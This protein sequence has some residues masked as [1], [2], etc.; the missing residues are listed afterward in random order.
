M[1]SEPTVEEIQQWRETINL[2]V[3]HGDGTISID[4]AE[5]RRYLSA[6]R[7]LA[8]IRQAG[9]L[10]PDAREHLDNIANWAG[11]EKSTHKRQ[12]SKDLRAVL[13]SHDALA[14][15]LAACEHYRECRAEP[16]WPNWGETPIK[17]KSVTTPDE[18]RAAAQRLIECAETLG[19][20]GTPYGKHTGYAKQFDERAVGEAYLRLAAQ[21]AERDETIAGLRERLAEIIAAWDDGDLSASESAGKMHSIALAALAK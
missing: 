11:A 6:A 21:L 10:E 8:A 19:G 16:T 15:Q 17:N 14:A 1:T 2:M 12:L 5:F 7:A 3:E 20:C 13:Q 18:L 9:G 4:G